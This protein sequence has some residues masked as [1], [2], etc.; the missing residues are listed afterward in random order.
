MA[1]KQES[2]RTRRNDIFANLSRFFYVRRKVRTSLATSLG[3]MFI[4]WAIRGIRIRRSFPAVR[5]C[6]AAGAIQAD[7][8]RPG[9]ASVRFPTK[10]RQRENKCFP[11]TI[12]SSPD[13]REETPHF[14]IAEGRAAPCIGGFPRGLTLKVA[15]VSMRCCPFCRSLD[16]R[17]SH[18]RGSLEMIVLPLLLLRTF[19][20]EDGTKRRYNFFFTRAFHEPENNFRHD[21]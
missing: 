3:H 21:A 8:P 19:R 15:R 16:V 13:R 1:R 14:S 6:K 17:R 10:G 20:S 5:V 12:D 18:R 7:S 4:K 9:F 2:R 11:R